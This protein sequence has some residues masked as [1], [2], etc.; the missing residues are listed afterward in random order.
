MN[1]KLQVLGQKMGDVMGVILLPLINIVTKLADKFMN[2]SP[3]TQK[4]ITIAVMLGAILGP[5]ILT[6]G[7]IVSAIGFIISPIGLVVVG[8]MAAIAIF[9]LLRKHLKLVGTIFLVALGPIG[10]VIFGI[11]FAV[12]LLIKHFDK[13]LAGLRKIRD[14]G[15]AVMDFLTPDAPGAGGQAGTNMGGYSS[16]PLV[17]SV[18]QNSNKTNTNNAAVEIHLKGATEGVKAKVTEGKNVSVNRGVMTA[19]A[20]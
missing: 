6:I 1:I 12:K 2:L 13:V 8:V 19:G 15:G 7:A 16:M 18:M 11:I 20:M 9:I 3:A 4:F 14:V 5:L 17:N 10:L